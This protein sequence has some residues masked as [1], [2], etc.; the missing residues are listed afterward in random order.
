M[1]QCWDLEQVAEILRFDTEG[2]GSLCQPAAPACPSRPAQIRG[3]S[4]VPVPSSVT[5][6]CKHVFTIPPPSSSFRKYL[7][8]WQAAS[9]KIAMVF[10]DAVGR[11]L[12]S[13][14]A[15]PCH[16]LPVT[17]WGAGTLGRARA[18]CGT[19]LWA[20]RGA[21]RNDGQS[22]GCLERAGRKGVVSPK[23][24]GTATSTPQAPPFP[25]PQGVGLE[26]LIEAGNKS[27]FL[28]VVSG[29]G[30]LL[31]S[32]AGTADPPEAQHAALCIRAGLA[33]RKLFTSCAQEPQ[34]SRATEGHQNS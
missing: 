23:Q 32:T 21:G 17:A 8:C 12:Q 7:H 29:M 13:F 2:Q 18:P 30:M 25:T 28:W 24:E 20:W 27:C 3:C 1:C 22:C 14:Q 6:S 11:E 10:A 33:T 16:P 5:F 4:E 31:W 19:W 15:F 26:A 34:C 9:S